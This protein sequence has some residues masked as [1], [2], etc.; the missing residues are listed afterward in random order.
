MANEIKKGEAKPEAAWHSSACI[1]CALNCGIK[2]Q[3]TED[4]R[5]AVWQIATGH[6]APR[7]G[8]RLE[9]RVWLA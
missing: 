6:E 1:L 2:V 3:L 4:G 5:D 8:C 7:V 9:D